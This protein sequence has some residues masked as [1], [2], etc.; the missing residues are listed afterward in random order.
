MYVSRSA[1]CSNGVWPR[2]RAGGRGQAGRGMRFARTFGF[3][4]YVRTAPR[5]SI[6]VVDVNK[7]KKQRRA[8]RPNPN[9]IGE[10]LGGAVPAAS[11][12]GRCT[13]PRRAT[14]RNAPRSASEAEKTNGAS[15]H[16]TC[17]TLCQL[18]SGMTVR[19]GRTGQ[20]EGGKEERAHGSRIGRPCGLVYSPHP[21]P[22]LSSPRTTLLLAQD[23]R[24]RIAARRGSRPIEVESISK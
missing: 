20:R 6:N 11:S 2:R 18:G 19:R 21:Q 5:P 12:R 16:V 9:P 15:E 3:R 1:S 23:P 22:P 14:Q 4:L 7:K 24:M 8:S 17:M 13:L 10:G